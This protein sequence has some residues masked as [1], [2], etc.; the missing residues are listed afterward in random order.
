MTALA[1]RH[2]AVNLGQGFP[3]FPSPDFVKRA[4]VAAIEQDVNQY[5]PSAGRP[6]L[7]EA[8]A[9]R[10]E[11]RYG[12]SV[13]PARQVVVTHGATEA[14]FASILALVDPGDE[15]ILFEPAYDSYL[16]SIGM[17]CGVP[18]C[19]TLRP[20]DWAVDR[21]ELAALFSPKTRLLL[22][23]TPHNPTG[24]VFSAAELGMIAELCLEHDVIAV[25]DEV[26]EHIVFNGLSHRPLATFPGMAD[27]TVTVSSLA[28][29]FSVTGWKVGW[30]AASPELAEAV[31]RAHQFITFS[32]AAPL[33]EAAATALA[34]PAAYYDELAAMYLSRRD[35][36]VSALRR[37]GLKPIV[38]QGTYFVMV[39]ID[40]LGFADDVAFCR[41]LTVEIGVAA[42]PPGAFY[43][44]P[45]DGRKLARFAF[46]KSDETLALAAER[47]QR[48][49]LLRPS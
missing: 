45:A 2:G 22:L 48:L 27:R 6:S 39:D 13:D 43:R 19:Y 9:R 28:K 41:Y 25:T 10:L 12:W 46:C 1:E 18:R 15:V 14:L 24:K 20:P 3:D 7:R 31:M 16:P 17:A 36:L 5:A 37:A 32:G 21:D 23:N 29:T 30:V 8:I 35:F 33:Q 42:I 44:N 11:R 4:A 40:G 47:L 26:Y 38:P 34:A 49:G